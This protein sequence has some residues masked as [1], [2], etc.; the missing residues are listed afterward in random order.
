MAAA[1]LGTEQQTAM[2]AAAQ[3]RSSGKGV[4]MPSISAGA[5]PRIQVAAVKAHAGDAQLQAALPLPVKGSTKVPLMLHAPQ[6]CALA[7]CACAS[8]SS[9]LWRGVVSL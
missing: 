8:M 2:A 9:D 4:D 5:Q 1:L 3:Q 7:G 6:V